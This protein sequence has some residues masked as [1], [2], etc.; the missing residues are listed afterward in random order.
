PVAVRLPGLTATAQA[1]GQQ[2]RAT[3]RW[4]WSRLTAR[5]PTRRWPLATREVE[6]EPAPRRPAHAVARSPHGWRRP[7]PPWVLRVA[8]A[9]PGSRAPRGAAERGPLAPRE[10]RGATRAA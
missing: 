4:G 3:R 1:P 2:A 6:L 9:P 10:P 5:W 8:G 7:N